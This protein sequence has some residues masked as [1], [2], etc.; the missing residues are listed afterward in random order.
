MEHLKDRLRTEMILRLY[1]LLYPDICVRDEVNQ[2][3][4]SVGVLQ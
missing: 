3:K 2:F 1:Q 4:K